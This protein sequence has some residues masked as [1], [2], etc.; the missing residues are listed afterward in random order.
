MLSQSRTAR[1]GYVVK[2]YPRY[3]ETFIVNEILEHEANGLQIDIFSLRPPVDTH[4]QDAISRVKAGVTYLPQRSSRSTGFWNSLLA[5]ASEMPDV[6][7]VLSET[8]AIDTE[9]VYHAAHLALNVRQRGI[10][11]LHAHF[12]SSPASV[13][14]LAS[15]FAGVPF[16]VTAHAKDVFHESVDHGDL[17][18]KLTSASTVVTV[19]DFNVDFLRAMFGPESLPVRRIYNGLDL[20]YFS[21]VPPVDRPRRIVAVG[22][23]VEKKGF[24]HLI[25]ACALLAR[26]GVTF[27]CQIIGSGPE[28]ENLRRRVTQL[29][30]DECVHLCGPLPQRDVIELLRSAAVF[31]A[32]CVAGTDGN[33]DG[34]PTVLLEAMALGTPCIS[35]P[36]TGIPEVIKHGVTGL[37]VPEADAHQLAT[38]M[39]HVLDDNNL[40]RLLSGNARSLR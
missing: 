33:R 6:W 21:Y 22:R 40:A 1:V 16:T 11:H 27:D 4:F 35:T 14:S 19:S 36:V 9:T 5:A 17:L 25:D 28:Q 18:R 34:L 20:N 2:R 30:L 31:A 13:A 3:S 15:A 23:L 8:P 37:M 7:R 26:A 12:A 38:A 29:G 32:P 39:E 10:T 24:I